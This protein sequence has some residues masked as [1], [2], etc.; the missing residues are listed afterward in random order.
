MMNDNWKSVVSFIGKKF[1]DDVA[2]DKVFEFLDKFLNN[3][4]TK[5]YVIDDLTPLVKNS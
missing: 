4:P 5:Y 3:V 1:I 2:V